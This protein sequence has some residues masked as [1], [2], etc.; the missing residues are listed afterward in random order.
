M[1]ILRI[2]ELASL[3]LTVWGLILLGNKKELGFLIFN[4]SLLCQMAIFVKQ[5]NYFLVCQMAV[6]IVFN[7]YNFGKWRRSK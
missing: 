2:V 6:L 7:S 1:D 5:N 3:A 4:G